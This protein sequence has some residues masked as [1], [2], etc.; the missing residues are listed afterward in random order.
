[1]VIVHKI[2]DC[3]AGEASVLIAIS[4]THRTESLQAVEFAIN[5]LKR[6]VPIW[7]KVCFSLY[8]DTL[9]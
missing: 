4:S 8:H 3:P 2:G 7:K 6:I 5:E 9:F 1:M